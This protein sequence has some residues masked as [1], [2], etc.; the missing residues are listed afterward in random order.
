MQISQVHNCKDMKKL[1][2]A[3]A[4]VPLIRGT[5]QGD[6]WQAKEA[7]D[8]EIKLR[9]E[10]GDPPPE[11]PA[12]LYPPV[13]NFLL[14]AASI[15]EE[16]FDNKVEIGLLLEAKPGKLLRTSDSN[17][18]FACRLMSWPRASRLP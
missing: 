16:K 3:K 17:E 15:A 12:A 7:K 11:A 13:F 6:W 18:P 5:Q 10:G 4:S 8:L 1:L 9:E 2:E 14:A